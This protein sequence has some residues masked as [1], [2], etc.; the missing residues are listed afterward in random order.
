MDKHFMEKDISMYHLILMAIDLEREMTALKIRIQ[1]LCA[2]PSERLTEEWINSQQVIS[3]LKIKKVTLQK[4]RDEG[5]I[6]FTNINGKIYYSSAD[7][8]AL[9]KTNYR[10]G[11]RKR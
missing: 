6:P 8:A 7:V 10:R 1:L 5:T 4:L 11:K 2:K 3:I 9:L